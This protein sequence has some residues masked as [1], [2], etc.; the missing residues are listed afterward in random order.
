[1]D[2]LRLFLRLLVGRKLYF[3]D[4][5]EKTID[6]LQLV[7]DIRISIESE[8]F[9]IIVISEMLNR[10]HDILYTIDIADKVLFILTELIIRFHNFSGVDLSETG[11]Q[12]L[13]IPFISD[14]ASII[15]LP[16]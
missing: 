12:T 8:Y 11:N 13:L 2:D 9:R 14:S 1:M 3:D 15:D 10:I 16:C 5:V 7:A 6:F 4:S